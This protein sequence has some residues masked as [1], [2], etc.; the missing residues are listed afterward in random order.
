MTTQ[1]PT[2][3]PR[4]PALTV[5]IIIEFEGGIVL[6]ER[7]NA[8]LGFALPGGFVDVGE[9]VEAAAVREALEETGLTVT[10]RALLGVYS[11]PARDPRQHTVSTVFVAEGRG[12]LMAADDA[13]DARAISLAQ[14]PTTLCFD[15]ARILADYKAWRGDGHAPTPRT[16]LSDSDRR[17]ISEL[18]WQTL[19]STAAVPISAVR[20]AFRGGPLS[21]P[22]ACFVTLK[23]KN[24]DVRGS[25][26]STVPSVTL[27]LA[28][29]EM[30]AAAALSDTT[31]PLQRSELSD[32]QVEVNVLAFTSDVIV[33]SDD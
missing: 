31:A 3:A 10:L 33:A 19:A 25:A 6:I 26:G 23:R 14:A 28:I 8:P 13:K 18:A 12:E 22:G 30:T 9:T 24:G 21:Q 15:H 2:S 11:D 20:P 16:P 7:K 29:E 27:A 17:T 32:I 1:P 4:S 5:D